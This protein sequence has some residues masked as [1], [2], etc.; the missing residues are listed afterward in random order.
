MT[1][2]D[3]RSLTMK[4]LQVASRRSSSP[5]PRDVFRSCLQSSY[6][7]I[8]SQDYEVVAWFT[9]VSQQRHSSQRRVRLVDVGS[10]IIYGGARFSSACWL[11][12][13]RCTSL[14]DSACNKLHCPTLHPPS[15]V[16][17]DRPALRQPRRDEC[18]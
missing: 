16:L 3:C 11:L 7:R 5:F 4:G 18:G 15:S 13:I 10:L 12:V 8:I 6:L 1:R 17:A 14:K 2:R 9:F